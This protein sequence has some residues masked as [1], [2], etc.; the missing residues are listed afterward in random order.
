MV[1]ET[2][3]EKL[4]NPDPQTQ[5]EGLAEALALENHSAV[6]EGWSLSKSEPYEPPVRDVW[7]GKPHYRWA[8]ETNRAHV[9]YRDMHTIKLNWPQF[10]YT[11]GGGFNSSIL[12]LILR[13]PD[14][15]RDINSLWLDG[16]PGLESLDLLSELK[17][18]KY[19]F[20]NNCS[21]LTDIGA[22]QKMDLKELGIATCRNLCDASPVASQRNLVVLELRGTGTEN[23]DWMKALLD[24]ECEA[25]H[26]LTH[27]GL[28]LNKKLK[29]LPTL[30]PFESLNVIELAGC[31]SLENIDGLYSSGVRTL[32]L[33]GC[34]TLKIFD[35]R[36]YRNVEENIGECCSLKYL[37]IDG[38]TLDT[39]QQIYGVLQLAE[40]IQE[41]DG[42][43]PHQWSE[44]I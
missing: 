11:G 25:N 44:L 1:I 27:L 30:A 39:D 16:C 41:N 22:I 29:S 31:T 2:I 34:N 15:D 33:E 6:I 38:S 42:Y 12:E 18:L 13:S 26:T 37:Y 17:H 4:T 9:Y 35:S 24:Q 21:G 7:E 32:N 28:K 19:L 36:G 10:K 3:R 23:L 8:K 43:V 40:Y 5:R 14:F 20:I